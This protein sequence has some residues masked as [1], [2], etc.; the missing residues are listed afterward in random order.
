[1]LMSF[2]VRQLDDTSVHTNKM[3]RKERKKERKKEKIPTTNECSTV[4]HH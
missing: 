3:G 1:M 2:T 4:C